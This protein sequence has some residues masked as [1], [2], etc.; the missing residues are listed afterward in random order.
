VLE[1]APAAARQTVQDEEQPMAD[2]RHTKGDSHHGSHGIASR[3][4]MVAVAAI[5][6]A[7]CGSASTP[8]RGPTSTTT[9]GRF[10]PNTV[11]VEI[12]TGGGFISPIGR[13]GQGA[14]VTVLGDGT[15][16]TPAPVAMIYPGPAI[17]PL[18]EGHISA[19]RIGALL[20]DADHLGLLAGPLDFGR[21]GVSD[22]GTTT[23]RIDDGTRVVVQSAYALDFD[24][25]N[26]NLTSA[27]RAARSALQSFVKE[28]QALPSGARIFSPRAVAVFTFEGSTAPTPASPTRA[29]PIATQ[30]AAPMS[31]RPGCVVVRGAEVATLLAALAQARENTPW[32]VGT[33]TLRLG[34]RPLVTSD[35]PCT[36]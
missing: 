9:P 8:S 2:G 26:G 31:G 24:T 13:V 22:M 16:V 17:A 30:P 6:S 21:P 23:V 7:A 4:A 27:Q 18:Q 10:A 33:R 14:S 20:A 15:V 35:A 32:R 36:L 1:L 19:A 25:A 12:A 3:V 29:W 34:F 11:I 28:V 5:S